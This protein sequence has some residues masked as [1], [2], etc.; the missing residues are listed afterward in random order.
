MNALKALSRLA[1]PLPSNRRLEWAD[2]PDAEPDE[3]AML[4]PKDTNQVHEMEEAPG[5]FMGS[6]QEWREGEDEATEF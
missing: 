6:F 5:W 4:G 3:W 2:W 1:L